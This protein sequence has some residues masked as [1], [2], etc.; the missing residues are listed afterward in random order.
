[1]VFGGNALEPQRL[2]KV[3]KVGQF[4]TCTDQL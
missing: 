1:M 3:V 2:E 4:V